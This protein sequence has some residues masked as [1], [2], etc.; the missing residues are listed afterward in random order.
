MKRN[1]L[2]FLVVLCLSLILA[3]PTG[4]LVN[5]YIFIGGSS[6]FTSGVSNFIEGFPLIY[7]FLLA[8]LF[9]LYGRTV[10]FISI[11]LFL[12]PIV[13]L[14]LYANAD[15]SVWFWSVIFFVVGIILAFILQKLFKRNLVSSI[16]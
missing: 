5:K 6:V 12:L 2:I 9:I 10:K 14:Y 16:Q 13:L 3:L 8:F 4:S 11:I 1:I 15:S 7:L